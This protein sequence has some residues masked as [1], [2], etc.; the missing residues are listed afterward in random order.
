[1][2]VLA[3]GAAPLWAQDKTLPADD[4]AP[5]TWKEGE[6]VDSLDY[7]QKEQQARFDSGAAVN[8]GT[9][10]PWAEIGA[11]LLWKQAPGIASLSIG[12]GNFEFSDTYRERNYI[13]KF[14]SQSAYYAN[15]YFP[16]PFGP[17]YI[18]PMAGLVRWEGSIF[19]RGTDPISDELASALTSKFTASGVSVGANF[20]LMWIF[21]N[22]IFVDYNL[23]GVT[24]AHLIAQTYST[25]SSEVRAN[26]RRQIRGPISMNAAHLRIGWSWLI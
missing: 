4:E 19:P 9:V 13:V 26:V 17:L 3:L 23:V 2:I 10:M 1:M 12:L 14:D 8:I 18:E 5:E 11:S 15:R 22:R 20:G 6:L 25:S 24:W 7:T 16:L 21:S